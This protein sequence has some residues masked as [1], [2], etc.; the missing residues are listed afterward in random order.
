MKIKQAALGLVLFVL[1]IICHQKTNGQTKAIT[2][3]DSSFRNFDKYNSPIP[4]NDVTHILFSANGKDKWVATWGGGLTLW[5]KKGWTTYNNANT[6]LGINF[7]N[8]MALD[9]KGKLWL[10]TNKRGVFTFDGK[11]WENIVIGESDVL[12][13]IAVDK[14]NNIWVGTYT[15]GLYKIENGVAIKQWGSATQGLKYAI[16]AICFDKDNQPW[17]S[18]GKGIYRWNGEKFIISKTDSSKKQ[19]IQYGL[20]TDSKGNIWC[21]GFPVGDIQKWDG[22]KWIKYEETAQKALNVAANKLNKTLDINKQYFKHGFYID[23]DDNIYLAT[24]HNGAIAKFDGRKWEEIIPANGKYEKYGYAAIVVDSI[25]KIFTGTWNHGIITYEKIFRF[26]T[27]K[28][29]YD[30]T[31]IEGRKVISD[32]EVELTTTEVEL[33]LWDQGFVDGDII[34]LYINDSLV[35][36]EYEL[37][38][39]KETIKYTFEKNSVNKIAIYAHN[40]GKVPPNTCTVTLIAG[41]KKYRYILNSDLNK[42][43]AVLIKIK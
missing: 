21:A 19:P 2:V 6:G 11:K 30:L 38:A 20:A 42:C 39:L 3:P 14:N 7:I 25:G 28:I 23:R 10:A 40:I 37:S 5:N 31:N 1:V 35:V 24:Q 22:E 13:S 4:C 36:K 8:D 43:A 27:D 41:A 26:T 29:V 18:T 33:Q 9:Q 16:Q 17:I 32:F 34:S 12:L 15:D